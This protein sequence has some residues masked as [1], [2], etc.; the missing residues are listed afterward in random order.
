MRIFRT[1]NKI[2]RF[3]WLVHFFL[4]A[5]YVYM[6]ISIVGNTNGKEDGMGLMEI[7]MEICVEK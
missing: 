7:K 2:E 4:D 1:R 3:F 6:Y 5:M